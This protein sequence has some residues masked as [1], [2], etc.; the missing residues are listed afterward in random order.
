MGGGARHAGKCSSAAA[1]PASAPA[2][3]AGWAAAKAGAGGASSGAGR[4]P[5]SPVSGQ[6]G[7]AG[8]RGRPRGEAGVSEAGG[9]RPCPGEAPSLNRRSPPRGRSD[10][11]AAPSGV[12]RPSHSASQ[13]PGRLKGAEAEGRALRRATR[14]VL[15]V[16]PCPGQRPT[17]EQ[18]PREAPPTGGEP[19]GAVGGISAGRAPPLPSLRLGRFPPVWGPFGSPAVSP[20]TE[21]GRSGGGA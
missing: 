18:G 13:L 2:D 21:G 11:G 12:G 16:E 19:E 3:S 17:G 10:V 14:R 15:R 8:V 9:G 7:A 1:L 4:A 6:V 20:W 5:R